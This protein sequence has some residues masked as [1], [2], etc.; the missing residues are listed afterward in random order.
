MKNINTMNQWER[1]VAQNRLGYHPQAGRLVKWPTTSG[2][3]TGIGNANSL[4]CAK[5]AH[6][7]G[8]IKLGPSLRK[9]A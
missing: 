1:F 9:Q 6:E 2:M 3:D 5:M 4:Y 8:M 7:Q